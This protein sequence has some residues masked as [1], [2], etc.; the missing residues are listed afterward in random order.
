MFSID[1]DNIRFSLKSNEL[2]TKNCETLLSTQTFC[3]KIDTPRFN[4]KRLGLTR[5][6]EIPHN[7]CRCIY[8]T[9]TTYFVLGWW[10][11]KEFRGVFVVGLHSQFCPGRAGTCGVLMDISRA[12]FV[13]KI[14][15]VAGCR[16][17]LGSV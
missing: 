15:L 8:T 12:P 10:I 13:L 9:S 7:R 3:L 11:F 4:T 6:L 16:I 17:S 14:S 2:L 5:C 1:F